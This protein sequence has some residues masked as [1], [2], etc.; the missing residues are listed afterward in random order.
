MMP[1]SVN[2]FVTMPSSARVMKSWMLSMSFVDPPDQIACLPIVVLGEREAVD[3]VI[4]RAPEIGR[5]MSRAS[6]RSWSARRIRA[7]SS[8][9]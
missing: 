9:R 7:S 1:T 4:E 6:I 8:W 2:T 5:R 3:V